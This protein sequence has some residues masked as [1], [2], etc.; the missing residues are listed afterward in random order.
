MQEGRGMIVLGWMGVCVCIVPPAVVGALAAKNDDAV[1]RE[2]WPPG[3]LA[4]E[5]LRQQQQLSACR[6]VT[7][8]RRVKFER[9]CGR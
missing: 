7:F 4:C 5:R 9:Q 8:E 2:P 1:K 3:V 6:R